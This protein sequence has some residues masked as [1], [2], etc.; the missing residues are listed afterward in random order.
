MYIGLFYFIFGLTRIDSVNNI[1]KLVINANFKDYIPKP[2]A[3]I[4]MIK[5]FIS[6][7]VFFITLRSYGQIYL[8]PGVDTSTNKVKIALKFYNNYIADFKGKNLPDMLKYWSASELKQRKIPDPI[9]YAL[10]D[11]PLYSLGYQKTILY[12]KP[13]AKYVHI[14]T[15]FSSADSLKNIMTM[16]ITNHYIKLDDNNSP[17]FISPLSINLSKW[18]TKKVR[19][20]TYYYPSYHK[21]NLKTANSLI[22]NILQLEKEWGLPSINIRYYFADTY[23]EVHQLRGFDYALLMG[24]LAKPSGI[25]DDKDNQVFCGGLDENYFHEVAHLYLNHLYPKSPIQEGLVV[26]YAGSMGHD[27]KWHLNRVNAYLLKHSQVNLNN[28][29]DFWYTDPYTNP[30]SAIQGLI[31]SL[32]F[33]KDGLPGLK[34]VMEQKNYKDIFEKE[35][36]ISANNINSFLREAIAKEI[37]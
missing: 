25:S 30:G 3:A 9:I 28:V 36:N 12:I 37:K 4:Y 23:D 10:N 5:F 24:N 21:F 2:F 22:K 13:T 1:I 6:F 26:L 20:I 17:Q 27:L 35:F 7:T 33:K 34:R 14:K 8:N 31:C 32:A 29:D 19:N 15:Q 16:A 11:Y 18:K